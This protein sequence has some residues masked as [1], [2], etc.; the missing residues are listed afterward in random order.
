MNLKKLVSMANL[1]LSKLPEYT[2]TQKKY[3]E[4]EAKYLNKSIEEIDLTA[5][6][7]QEFIAETKKESFMATINMLESR[8]RKTNIMGA[9]ALSVVVLSVLY[10][11]LSSVF[12]WF[13]IVGLVFS[14]LPLVILPYGIPSYI[15]SLKYTKKYRDSHIKITSNGMFNYSQYLM[16]I[17][18]VKEEETKNTTNNNEEWQ[19]TYEQYKELIEELNEL[20]KEKKG[21]T[22]GKSTN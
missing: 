16:L 2:E 19:F 14:L 22:D 3:L 15:G 18:K 6:Q 12:G 21:K 1:E 10:T 5:P 17:E 20:K 4:N 7:I 9:I 11:I 8:L 13:S